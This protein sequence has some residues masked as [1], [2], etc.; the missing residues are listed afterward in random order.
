M[1][2]AH[3]RGTARE[4]ANA[5][6]KALREARGVDAETVGQ[7]A[8][9]AVTLLRVLR[10]PTIKWM[11][12][13]LAHFVKYVKEDLIQTQGGRE[14]W[15]AWA[16]DRTVDELLQLTGKFILPV[17]SVQAD[18][19]DGSAPPMNVNIIH[20]FAFWRVGGM[21]GRLRDAPMLES[22]EQSIDTAWRVVPSPCST[23]WLADQQV[24][25]PS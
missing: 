17:R 7:A 13:E 25:L 2:E 11:E 14:V 10:P 24:R 6:A 1:A 9:S 19:P 16:G 5:K 4:R 22:V 20:G 21:K 12:A 18:L 23:G 15:K 8:A 3:R